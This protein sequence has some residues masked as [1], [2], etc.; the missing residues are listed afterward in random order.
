M[1]EFDPLHSYQQLCDKVDVF[2]DKVASKHAASMQCASGCYD[3]CAAGLSVTLIEAASIAWYLAESKPE[4][5]KAL[6]ESDVAAD[7]SGF[8]ALDAA[9]QCRIYTPRPLVCLSHGVPIRSREPDNGLPV[10][11][12]C[13]RNFQGEGELE[14]VPEEDQL[15]QL[16][17]STMLA[18]IDAA[19]V[20]TAGVPRGTRLDLAEFLADPFAVFGVDE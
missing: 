7:G 5:L 1:S 19:F 4:L 15:D 12:T 9:G 11:D 20:D 6:A 17:L 13:F 8:V 16:N 2:F 10:F 18:A 14:S 3:C